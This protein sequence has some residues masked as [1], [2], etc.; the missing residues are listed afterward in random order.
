M[1][2]WSRKQLCSF[3][4]HLLTYFPDS[5]LLKTLPLGT[6]QPKPQQVLPLIVLAKPGFQVIQGVR[7][8][9]ED[10]S[11]RFQT[12]AVHVI[13]SS[14]GRDP[15][16]RSRNKPCQLGSLQTPDTRIYYKVV[17]I[18]YQ[19]IL[20]GSVMHH[21]LPQELQD[22]PHWFTSS[23]SIPFSSGHQ[24][25][26]AHRPL[27]VC[28]PLAGDRCSKG[29][30]KPTVANLSVLMDHQLATAALKHIQETKPVMLTVG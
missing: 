21:G 24:P 17:I 28:R 22:N 2:V 15:T 16:S 19:Y 11:R 8:V 23:W 3:C 27:V 6:W 25:F 4:L 7:C 13:Y 18:L 29:F 20:G 14:S 9:S 12:P 1:P 5:S 10:L 30:L 26:E